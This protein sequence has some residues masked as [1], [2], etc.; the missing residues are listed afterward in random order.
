MRGFLGSLQQGD[1]DT[2]DVFDS[3]KTVIS[4]GSVPPRQ[5]VCM[6]LVTNSGLDDVSDYYSGLHD[7]GD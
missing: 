4:P 3:L 6:M 1:V 7:V 2:D 5:V